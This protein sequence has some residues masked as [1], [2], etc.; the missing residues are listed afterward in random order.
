MDPRDLL[1]DE[2]KQIITQQQEKI[3]SLEAV[4]VAL[5]GQIEELAKR[6]AKNSSN[7]SKPPSTDGLRKKPVTQ[8]LRIKTGKKTG[9]Q[10]GHK[11]DTL[12][13]VMHPD[14]VLHHAVEVCSDCQQS[15][16]DVASTE[17]IK[18]QVFD[19]PVPQ[20]VV[21]EHRAE[22][23]VCPCCQT[24]VIAQFPTGIHAPTQY[25]PVLQ[26]YGVYLHAQQL[27]PEARLQ[28][29]FSDLFQVSLATATLNKFSD[30]MANQL[31]E[32]KAI[33]LKKVQEAS[34][35]HLDETGCRIQGKTQWLHVACTQDWTYYHTASKRKSL[36]SGLTGTV[37][38]DHFKP[39]FQLEGVTH[40]PCHAHHLRE[41]KSL[42]ED[43]EHWAHL[44]FRLL[45]LASVFKRH[46][47]AEGIPP[48]KQARLIKL[49]DAII[50][51]GLSYHAQLPEYR[52]KPKRG[53]QAQHPGYNL[54][55]RLKDRRGEALRFIKEHEVPFTNNQAEQDIR[56]MKV[57]QK[58]SGG[59]RSEQGAK[60]F[61]DLR[62]Y[63][64]TARKQGLNI[65]DAIS[66]A[67]SGDA[68]AP[69]RNTAITR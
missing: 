32:F 54:L 13:Q 25:G 36:L 6:V 45:V 16:K 3:V 40:A 26:S 5:G 63:I 52:P 30:N 66:S 64:S 62:A 50:E 27:I 24:R 7:S 61:V 58:I 51:R 60:Q 14:Q 9:G 22:V 69:F 44:M 57:K 2:L 68:M 39:Y 48:D 4:I 12:A 59:F 1:I 37:V 19:I 42:K 21:T 35:K 10:A 29:T 53:K 11:G 65:L 28:Q 41:L 33:S 38:H 31:G 55:K 23:K 20:Q 34:V 56:M 46:Y 8:S 49:Y 67:L 43:N 17:V 18:R 47:Q 15:L